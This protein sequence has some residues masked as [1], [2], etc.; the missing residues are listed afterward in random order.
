MILEEKESTKIFVSFRSFRRALAR[1]QSIFQ[2]EGEKN[3]EDKM[4]SKEY[5]YAYV[6]DFITSKWSVDGKS[7][8]SISQSATGVE[9]EDYREIFREGYIIKGRSGEI[10]QKAL[11]DE[12]KFEENLLKIENGDYALLDSMSRDIALFASMLFY[13]NPLSWWRLFRMIMDDDGRIAKIRDDEK[14]FKNLQ[15]GINMPRNTEALAEVLATSSF[16]A[17]YMYDLTPILLEAPQGSSFIL[18]CT[19]LVVMNFYAFSEEGLDTSFC[20]NG[21]VIFIPLSPKYALS[22][23][24]S[25]VYKPKKTSGRILLTND[26][27]FDINRFICLFN[28]LIVFRPDEYHD[29]EYYVNFMKTVNESNI[30]VKDITVPAFRIMARAYDEGEGD[31]RMFPRLLNVY[32]SMKEVITFAERKEVIEE[33]LKKAWESRDF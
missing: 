27:L 10:K 28:S 15:D 26:E 20:E 3:M 6:P 18:G 30:G 29:E 13:S 11:F 1:V 21:A 24:D 14:R 22:L 8:S 16:M 2:N 31:W 7:V 23:Y 25:F 19:P 4:K 17:P 32:D 33:L 12:K 9:R 5:S